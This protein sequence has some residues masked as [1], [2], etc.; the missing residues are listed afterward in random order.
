MATIR[1]VYELDTRADTTGLDKATA[2]AKQL[3]HAIDGVGNSATQASGKMR[4]LG[5]AL[6]GLGG[7]A[8][9][10][11]GVLKGLAVGLAS[12]AAGALL[13]L[14]RLL[15]SIRGAMDRAAGGAAGIGKAAQAAASDA[16]EATRKV[17]GLAG[18]W[19]DVGAGYVMAAGKRGEEITERTSELTD[20]MEEQAERGGA[21]MSRFG[22]VL[23]RIGARLKALG[24]IF[25][26]AFGKALLPLLERLLVL[27]EDPA[28][29]EFVTLLAEDLADAI[30]KIADWIGTKAIP[31]IS[32]WIRW[33]N[34][35][36]GPV[37]TVK[38]LWQGVGT[39]FEIVSV[40]VK[41]LMR[42]MTNYITNSINTWKQNFQS[43]KAIVD[44]VIA[45]IKTAFTGLRTA[46]AAIFNGIVLSIKSSLNQVLEYINYVI[47]IYNRIAKKIGLPQLVEVG[48][49]D[50][51][52]DGEAGDQS[53]RGSS[54]AVRGLS[55]SPPVGER[56]SSL[57]VRGLSASPPAGI[58]I[59]NLTIYASGYSEGRTAAE[60]FTDYLRG[61]A[62]AGVR[63]G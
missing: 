42:E 6:S 4:G 19:G 30:V 27:L 37:E 57:A 53:A 36:G 54:L 41:L 11:G 32:E 5:G 43:F 39:V 12:L 50:T 52:D 28:T 10:L 25:L 17:A 15:G 61:A 8:R 14:P 49:F 21:A 60:V 63:A 9:G 29:E 46:I 44:V 35:M 7:I 38:K 26:R 23:D 31:K 16:G 47:G 48:L 1:D 51:G 24:D 13:G 18:A 59:G 62:A 34:D 45:G 33:I 2:D 55:A 3:D 22:T 40:I 20:E 58:S 56:G